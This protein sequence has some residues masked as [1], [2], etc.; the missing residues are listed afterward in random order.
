[1]DQICDEYL[2]MAERLH[3]GSL[4]LSKQPTGQI[5][6]NNRKR[7]VNG[8]KHQGANSISNKKP[9]LGLVIREKPFQHVILKEISAT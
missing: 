7:K 6:Q 8:S 4:T 9:H 1:M 5:A 2:P 3:N